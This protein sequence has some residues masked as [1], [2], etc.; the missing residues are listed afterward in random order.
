MAVA[1]GGGASAGGQRQALAQA[2]EIESLRRREPVGRLGERAGRP[3][4]R[5]RPTA[6]PRRSPTISAAPRPV[7]TIGW[8][9]VFSSASAPATPR[10]TSG[11]NGFLGR[12]WTDSVSAAAYG[13][14]TQGAFYADALA[15]YAYSNNRLQRQIVIPGL[16]PRTANGSTGANQASRPGREPATRSGAL[17]AGPGD[18]HAVRPPADLERHP[19][20]LLANGAAPTRSTSTWRSRPPTRCEAPWVRIWLASSGW[21]TRGSSISRFGWAGC[22]NLPTPA[23]RSRRL[24]PARRPTPSLST[25][26]RR[27]ATRRSSASRPG[28]P[29]PR[30]PRSISATTA[31]I[32]SGNDNHALNIGV[33]LTW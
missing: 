6:M 19:E 20:W 24:S 1:R 32:G 18:A 10:P 7:S 2:C 3:G 9:R 22:T 23:G 26:P 5:R 4:Q 11:S 31:E 15:G 8:I 21:A 14:F 25:A 27:S 28:P 29:S 16:Q 33:R 12:G 17:R 30:R 13:S